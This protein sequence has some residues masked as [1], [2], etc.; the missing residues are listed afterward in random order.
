MRLFALILAV[1]C[2]SCSQKTDVRSV[3]VPS[4]P[5]ETALNY[6]TKTT[7]LTVEVAYETGHEPYADGS[8]LTISGNLVPMWQVLE[9]NLNALFLGRTPFPLIVVPKQLSEMKQLPAMNRTRWEAKDIIELAD[10]NRRNPSTSSHT[11]FWVV[12]LGGVFSQDGIDQPS[13]IGVSIGGTTV[14]AIFKDVVRSTGVSAVPRY[15]E[16][17]TVVHEMG[18]AL[19]LVNNGLTLQDAHQDTAHGHHCTNTDCVMYWL[20]EGRSDMIQFAIN[21]SVSGSVIMFDQQ[22]LDDARKF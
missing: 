17:S 22:C 7:T 9:E 14:I 15:V 5:Y 20:N 1:L 8:S 3:K 10:R 13:T 11:Y 18:H 16:Q 4:N 19:G 21:M 12:F 6:F 2:S